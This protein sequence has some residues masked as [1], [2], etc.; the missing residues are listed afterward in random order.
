MPSK[1]NVVKACTSSPKRQKPTHQPAI[2]K[3][4]IGWTLL[5]IA[6]SMPDPQLAAHHSV[7]MTQEQILKQVSY[8]SL[9]VNQSSRHQTL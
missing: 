9:H 4:Q 8:T 7:T 2:I 1:H 5:V 6:D 3:E